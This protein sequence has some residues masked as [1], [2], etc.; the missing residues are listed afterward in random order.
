V[1]TWCHALKTTLA[2]FVGEFEA[3]LGARKR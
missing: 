1:R 3:G 2:A